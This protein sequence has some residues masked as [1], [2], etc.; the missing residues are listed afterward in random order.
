MTDLARQLEERATALAAHTNEAMYRD[1]FWDARFGEHGRSFAQQDGE[2]HVSYLAQAV[3]F[4]SADIIENYARWLR[5]VLTTRGMCS[6][7]II[8]TYDRLA[9]ALRASDLRDIDVAV[10]Y[11]DAA[12]AAVLYDDG[13]AQQVQ[14]ASDD[15]ARKAADRLL[16]E[17]PEWRTSLGAD[18]VTQ[19]AR[20][21]RIL[22]S[23]LADSIALDRPD[24][25]GSHAQW[26]TTFHEERGFP[27][28]YISALV[29][30][31]GVSLDTLPEE[32]RDE[33]R[34]MLFS[35]MAAVEP[36][37]RS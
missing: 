33:A 20:D 4:N 10:G 12:K 37:R 5:T 35:G 27:S 30:A 17:H 28:R 24:V 9:D 36:A 13:P 26:S 11:L 1:P 31:L 6:L 25:F 19:V 8:D 32:T 23:Y 16:S 29:S 34:E 15:L 7:H 2:H 14:A 22:L 18:A 3:R 21:A